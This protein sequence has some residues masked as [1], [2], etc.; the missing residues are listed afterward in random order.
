M[1][2]ELWVVRAGEQA[3]YAEDFQSGE[4]IAVDFTDFF[5]DDLDGTSETGLRQRATSPWSAPPPAS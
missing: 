4:Y 1:A 5:P 2:E 3:R